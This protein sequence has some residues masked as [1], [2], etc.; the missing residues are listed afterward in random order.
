MGSRSFF[1]LFLSLSLASSLSYSRRVQK[2]FFGLCS[3]LGE[4]E[5]ENRKT[6]RAVESST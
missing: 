4:R 1:F 6:K 5:M 2:Y 3:L